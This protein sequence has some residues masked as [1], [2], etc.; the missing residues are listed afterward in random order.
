MDHGKGGRVAYPEMFGACQ[1]IWVGFYANPISSQIGSQLFNP[2][3][4]V[5][6]NGRHI[7]LTSPHSVKKGKK[8]SSV[9]FDYYASCYEPHRR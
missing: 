5:Q 9:Y 2:L 6:N 4:L 8:N 3:S 1:A 7:I